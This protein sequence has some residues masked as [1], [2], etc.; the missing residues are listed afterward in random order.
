MDALSAPD[1]PVAPS[2]FETDANAYLAFH[3]RRFEHLFRLLDELAKSAPLRRILDV[4]PFIQTSMTR[5][6][7]PDTDVDTLGFEDPR[8]PRRPNDT[9][10]DLDL[11]SIPDETKRPPI[12]GYDVIV[13]AE[14]L[15]H[16]RVAPL[17]VLRWLG[18]ALRPGGHLIVQTPNACSIQK[19]IAM[20]RGRNP[21]EMITIE[22]VRAPDLGHIREYT[23]RELRELG[24]AAH[25]E[26]VRSLAA[27]YFNGGRL[28]H[29]AF[30]SAGPLLPPGLRD[31]IT[32]VYRRR[33]SV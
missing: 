23:V 14:V 5:D 27:N 10:Y 11:N 28:I 21:F 18:S 30:V 6:R 16:L 2:S 32:I 8:F 19:R 22:D 31:G 29:K 1:T 33:N 17:S 13:L 9:H 4:G 24:V 26:P 20:I 15:E 25:L 12:G 7:F 3:R